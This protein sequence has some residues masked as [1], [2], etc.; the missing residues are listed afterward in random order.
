MVRLNARLAR[1]FLALFLLAAPA[2]AF[3]AEISSGDQ[4]AIRSIIAGQLDAFQRDDGGAAYGY[5][6]PGIRAVFPTVDGFMAMVKK[7]F[8][9]LY[10]PQSSTFGPI[11]DSDKGPLQRLFVTGPDGKN[12]I[13]EY[14]LQRQPDGTWKIK[15]CKLLEDT[16]ATF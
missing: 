3:A 10:R 12:W 13:A 9:P 6:S 5:A 11:V 8:Q 1:F 2:A 4:A 15:G 14:T 7:G 16:G